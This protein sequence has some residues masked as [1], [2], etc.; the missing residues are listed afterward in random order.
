MNYSVFSQDK[1]EKKLIQVGGLGASFDAIAD[2]AV[3]GLNIYA[4]HNLF[5]WKNGRFFSGLGVF[6]GTYPNT[7]KSINRYTKGRT[8]FIYPVHVLIGHQFLFFKKRL[9]LRSALSA[10]P[11][12]FKQ[13][14]TFDDNRFDLKETY[15]YSEV[16]F[17]IHSKIGVAIKIGERSNFELYTNLPV[18]NRK[19]APLGFGLTMNRVF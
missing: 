15:K 14:I 2:E 13:K 3:L 18:V 5:K 16:V 9:L 12:V 11:S 6:Y 7:N 1:K 10:G 8:S 17:T 19:I 4:E